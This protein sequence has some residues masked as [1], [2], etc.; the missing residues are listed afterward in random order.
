LRSLLK[1]VLSEHLL[2]ASDALETSVFPNS[3]EAKP[4]KGLF[5]A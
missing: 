4:V 1:G 5:R 2:V 3:R